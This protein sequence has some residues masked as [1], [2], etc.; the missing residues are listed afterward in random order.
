MLPPPGGG[1]IFF[2][3]SAIAGG[4]PDWGKADISVMD[5]EV[6]APCIFEPATGGAPELSRL[7]R[8]KAISLSSN[9]SMESVI[10]VVGTSTFLNFSIG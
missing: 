5:R 7:A 4:G 3:I 8:A 10:R 1:G 6:G 9:L 2:I